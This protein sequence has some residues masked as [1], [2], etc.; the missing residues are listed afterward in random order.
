MFGDSSDASQPACPYSDALLAHAYQNPLLAAK[1]EAAIRDMARAGKAFVDC[2]P[3]SGGHRS[4][5][6]QL[7]DA[8][9]LASES[10]DKE[11]HRYA[12][13][14]KRASDTPAAINLEDARL[15]DEAR[16]AAGFEVER[17]TPMPRMTLAE[18][19]KQFPHRLPQELVGAAGKKNPFGAMKSTSTASAT[20]KKCVASAT[21]CCV[22]CS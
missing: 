11:P 20:A 16:V 21:R 1:V 13:V 14:Y 22:Q 2:Q 18:A 6:H 17:L 8:Y 3:M 19:I 15:S 4:F 10:F 7:A 12:R 9:G 5:V